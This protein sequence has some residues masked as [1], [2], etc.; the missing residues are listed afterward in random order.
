MYR[1]TCE[2][3]DWDVLMLDSVPCSSGCRG[4]IYR[5]PSRVRRESAQERGEDSSELE[6]RPR[7]QG[8]RL[9]AFFEI[10]V[11]SSATAGW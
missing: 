10:V 8:L 1:V 3:S 4:R 2:V 11:E 6:C 7:V 9:G 5:L